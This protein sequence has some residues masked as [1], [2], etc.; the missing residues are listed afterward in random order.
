MSSS[1]LSS[2]S[3]SARVF[4]FATGWGVSSFATGWGV[5]SFATGCGVSSFAT[6][7]SASSSATSWGVS[8]R[9]LGALVKLFTPLFPPAVR[10][11]LKFDSFDIGNEDALLD[12]GGKAKL[13]AYLDDTL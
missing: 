9:L 5:S 4:S 1:L 13:L 12:A 6:G 3:S 10:K 11:K 2:L 7:W 8:T